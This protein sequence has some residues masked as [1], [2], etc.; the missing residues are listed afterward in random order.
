MTWE[1]WYHGR[2]LYGSGYLA[3]VFEAEYPGWWELDDA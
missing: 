1:Y 2:Q 3:T